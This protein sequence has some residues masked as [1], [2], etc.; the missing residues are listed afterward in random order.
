MILYRERLSPSWWMIVALGLVV[1]A[2]VLIFL[3]LNVVVG[4]VSGFVR[5]ISSVAVLWVFSPVIA[6][7]EEGLR[8]GTA[9]LEREFWGQAQAFRGLEARH[10]RGPGAHGLA[11]LSLRPWIDPVVKIEVS[12]PE[13]PTPYWLI[14]SKNPEALLAALSDS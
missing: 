12:D 10:E 4:V 3:P 6:V 14:S 13:D 7:T 2:T 8:V 11:W 5:W 9:Y 1:P